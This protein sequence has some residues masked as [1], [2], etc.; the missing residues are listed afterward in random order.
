MAIR[1][2]KRGILLVCWWL[3]LLYAL[4]ACGVP[5]TVE[6]EL[7]L[8]VEG[9]ETPEAAARG[10]VQV[11]NEALGDPALTSIEQRRVWSERLT[12]Y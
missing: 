5:A 10:F 4:A 8:E 6:E 2:H 1:A 12:S 9:A 7:V 3:V 11:L